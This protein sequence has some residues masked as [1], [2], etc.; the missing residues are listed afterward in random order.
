MRNVTI[1]WETKE[2]FPNRT[3][4]YVVTQQPADPFGR[5]MFIVRRGSPEFEEK[6]LELSVSLGEEYSV[7]VRT[8]NCND[9]QQGNVVSTTLLL[10]GMK[11]HVYKVVCY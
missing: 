8:D 3:S 9:I 6:Q 1:Y 10:N 2:E 7:S 11:K 4:G 5:E